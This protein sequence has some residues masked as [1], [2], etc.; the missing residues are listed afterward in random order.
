MF[1][2][3]FFWPASGLISFC[4]YSH[5]LQNPALQASRHHPLLFIT[6]PLG[7]QI[8]GKMNVVLVS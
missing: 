6:P 2:I 4:Y 8:L 5:T 3:L 1:L 7:G